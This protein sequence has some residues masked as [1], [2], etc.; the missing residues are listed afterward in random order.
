MRRSSPMPTQCS[1]DLFGYEAVEGRRLVAAFDGGEVTSDAG[2][3]L[4]G[5]TDRAI[6]LVGRFAACF[7]DERAQ[8]QVEHSIAA[9]VAQRVF[10]IALG[11]EDVVDHDQLR[12]DRVLA[13]LAGK[14][15]AK[16]QD[17]APLAGKSTLN[18]LEHAP[19]TPSRYHKI[20]HDP[21]AI[22]GLFVALFLEAHKTPP[23]E[24]I[25]D[26]DATD[27]PLHGHREGR[28]FHGYY[29]G[30]CDLPLYVFCGR[31]LL[32]AKL[33]RSNID[34]PAGAVEEVT[35]IVDQ[36]RARWPRVS[37]LL[38][39]DSGFARDELRA[40]C[41]ANG[42]DYVFGLARNQRLVGAIADDL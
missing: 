30:Y 12:H 31:H 8:A 33:R 24:I 21:A 23:K 7:V 1:R 11:Y 32:A 25:L 16:R 3:L 27:D 13:T 22:E 14:L 40:W 19:L 4:L 41:E 15:T 26:L 38:R 34:A 37:I 42:V 9:M 39:A 2:G 28:F 35:R 36:I 20:G 18:R 10:G 17:C 29:D 6:G 5:A